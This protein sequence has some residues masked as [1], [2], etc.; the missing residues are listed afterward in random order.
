MVGVQG[1]YRFPVVWRFGLVGFAGVGRVSSTISQLN[2]TGLKDSYG[3]G[4]R[5]AVDRAEKLNLRL[6]FG[7]GRNSSGIYFNL[8]E[9]F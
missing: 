3:F 9:A 5:Y 1:E 4:V 7:W 2:F 8:T 6:D